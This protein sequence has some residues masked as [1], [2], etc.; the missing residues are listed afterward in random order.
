MPWI[1]LAGAAISA[2]VSAKNGSDQKKA[3]EK[4]QAA[5]QEQQDYARNGPL[6]STYAPGGAAAYN[7]A[8]Q[9]LGVPGAANGAYAGGPQ[10][11]SL[12]GGQTGGT[13]QKKYVGNLDIGGKAGLIK[14]PVGGAIFKGTGVD[15][16]DP[17][18]L[19]G[20]HSKITPIDVQVDPSKDWNAFWQGSPDLQKEWNSNSKLRE[21]FS[22]DP[23]KYAAYSYQNGLGDRQ[24][25]DVNQAGPTNGAGAPTGGADGQLSQSQGMTQAYQ[26]FLD[27]TGY[28]TNLN[29]G[30]DAVNSS[31]AAKGLLNSGATGKALTRF[32]QGLG[33]SYFN[34]YIQQLMGA[35][36][37]GIQAGSA[38]LGNGTALTG[39]SA[40]NTNQT[41]AITA[42]N[43][44]NTGDNV[45]FGL[46]S[47]WGTGGN[48]TGTSKPST[49]GPGTNNPSSGGATP[50]STFGGP[51]TYNPYGG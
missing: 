33:A 45:V 18:G 43:N 50:G 26:N 6:G 9:L 40:A 1:L 23:N 37:Q 38:V 19:L 46:N 34:N 22:N 15:I 51:S 29:A 2:G 13:P 12:V 17:A 35:S 10:K 32:G 25:N 14:D 47:V 49:V 20:H 21:Q 16:T 5:I 36:A 4:S 31:Q 24:L 48:N 30:V 11:T 8:L 3:G 7:Y 28:K 42:Q 41:A 39:Q 27:S 44:Q